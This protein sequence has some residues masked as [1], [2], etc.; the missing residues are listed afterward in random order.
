[1]LSALLLALQVAPPPPP[2]APPAMHAAI[3]PRVHIHQPR[4]PHIGSHMIRAIGGGPGPDS[5]T[6][7]GFLA[8]L[9]ETPV[10]VCGMAVAMLGNG[11]DGDGSPNQVSALRDDAVS[12]REIRRRLQS[13]LQDRR[14]IPL[15]AAS[16]GRPEP[17]VRRAAAKMLGGSDLPEASK[18]LHAGLRQADPRTRE[19]AALGIGVMADTAAFDELVLALGD[20]DPDVIRMA[21]WALG[22]LEDAR[23]VVPLA[24]LVDASDVGVRAAVAG[25]L[26]EI[27]DAR[28]VKPLL[29]LLRDRDVGVRAAAA[30][31]LGEIE[32]SSATPGLPV[33]GRPDHDYERE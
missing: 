27:E 11:W 12:Q 20:R 16:L 5:A 29:G 2:P 30:R 28:G 3:A 7:A 25:A 24:K 4:P 15:L 14:A 18:A 9:A 6:V 19:A 22:N 21:A 32:D 1:M 26:G 17:C 10:T 13:P 31:S 8:S 23:A 33:K